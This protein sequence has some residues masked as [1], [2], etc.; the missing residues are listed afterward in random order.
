MGRTRK[1]RGK[2]K[3]K[4]KGKGKELDRKW[5]RQDGNKEEIDLIREKR[6]EQRQSVAK[7]CA[8]SSDAERHGSSVAHVR[9]VT[10]GQQRD[11]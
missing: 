6:V 10:L 9:V 8:C 7:P 2:W 11:H 5:E 4:G 3:G 1:G